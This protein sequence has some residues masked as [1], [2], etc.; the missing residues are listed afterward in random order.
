MYYQTAYTSPIGKLTL[1]CDEN[2]SHLVGL[3]I[4]GQKYFGG[5]I[6]N[7]LTHQ[8]AIPLLEEAKHW[9]DCYF[10]GEKPD[11]HWL[12]LKPMGSAFRQ[13][14]WE[15]LQQIPY[16]EV[17]SYSEIAKR[18]AAQ[19]GLSSMSAQAVGGAVGHNPI[20]ILIPCH[21]VIGKNHSL[22]GY[23]GGVQKKQW[24]LQHERVDIDTQLHLQ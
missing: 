19:R 3:W 24:L 15:I 22:T 8:D 18:I 20:S 16:G 6:L 7:E 11:H 10:D 5:T 9:L 17:I 4:E 1:A 21:R 14:V 12:P 2:G 13:A 23:A